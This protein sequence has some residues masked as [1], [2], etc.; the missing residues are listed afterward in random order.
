M[1]FAMRQTGNLILHSK[2]ILM[3]ESKIFDRDEAGG[4]E[5]RIRSMRIVRNS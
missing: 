3:D 2:S 4:K 1:Q 5:Q